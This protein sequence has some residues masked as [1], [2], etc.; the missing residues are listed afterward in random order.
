MAQRSSPGTQPSLFARLVRRRR[1]VRS[2]LALLA[3]MILYVVLCV[4]PGGHG[5]GGGAWAQPV[6]TG[7]IATVATVEGTCTRLPAR[8]AEWVET[9]A[10]GLIYGGDRLKCGPDSW[11][12]ID[13]VDGGSVTL[14]PGCEVQ[15][16][17]LLYVRLFIGR[18][19]ARIQP[20]AP[21]GTGFR[22]ETPSAVVG[23]RGTHF[24]V[25]VSD[26]YATTVSVESGVVEVLGAGQAVLVPEGYATRV[27]RGQAPEEPGPMG[28]DEKRAWA[29]RRGRLKGQ[30][31]SDGDSGYDSGDKK[32]GK[33]DVHNGKAPGPPDDR[34]GGGGKG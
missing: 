31:G 28:D 10:G 8:S 24:T 12:V 27:R 17:S 23:V 15:F 25:W 18:L 21:G 7:V 34:P 11:A 13:L 4:M 19:W 30:T 33:Q 22:V 5:R 32:G 26:E 29:E 2:Y 9:R 20:V 6:A 14:G 3:I 16:D 1:R